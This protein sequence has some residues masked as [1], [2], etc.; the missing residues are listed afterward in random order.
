VTRSGKLA[1]AALDVYPNELAAN[2]DYFNN[3][4]NAW[5]ADRPRWQSGGV[6]QAELSTS[7]KGHLAG[8]N[9]VSIYVSSRHR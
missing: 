9:F 2:G 3:E 1:G 4:L 7:A 8:G 5:R 6:R